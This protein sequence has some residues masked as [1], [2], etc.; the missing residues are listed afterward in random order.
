MKKLLASLLMAAILLSMTAMPALAQDEAVELNV[1]YATSRPMNEATDLTRQYIRETLGVDINLTQGDSTN[2]TQQ[3]ALY[4]SSGDMPDV[5]WLSFPVWKE[6]AEEGAWAD[7]SGY[8]LDEYTDLNDYVGDNWAYMTVD[9]GIYGVPSM[10]SVPSSHVSFI[11]QDWLDKLG[12]EM[13][14]TLDELTD[15]FRAF[16]F[17]DPD[18]D[19]QNN[20]YGLSG[21]GYSYLSF[22]LGAYGASTAEAYFLNDDQTITTNAIS[23]GYKEGLAYLRDIY[24]EGLIDPEMFT[25]TYEQCQAKWGRGEMGVWSAWWS[26]GGNAYTRFDFGNLQPDANVNVMLPPTGPDGLSGN[27]YAAPFDSVVGISYKCSEEKIAAAV[28]L[29][30]FQA[31]PFGY[32]TVQYGVEGDFFEWDADQNLTTWYWGVNNS[33]SKSGHEITDMEVYKML[34]HEDWQ[35]Q[36]NL[37]LDTPGSRMHTLGSDMRY[38]EP[39]RENLFAMIL[40]PEYLQY[41]AELETF[42]K[43]SMLAFIMGEKNLDTDWDHYVAEYLSMGG[44]AARQAQLTAYNATMGTSYTFA[45]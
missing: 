17:D 25:A 45:E 24:A 36:A 43:T 23:A 41:K 11:R 44:E 35:A 37:L 19:G 4:I 15:V 31:G 2:F 3:L 42:F 21:A 14:A 33:T 10:L 27:L 9:G 38:Q 12:L 8:L 22:L 26:H 30:N 29:L 1:F 39:V 32:R 5:V 20:T 13:P 40:T 18:G 7:I 34:Y 6:Y 28:K 16:T